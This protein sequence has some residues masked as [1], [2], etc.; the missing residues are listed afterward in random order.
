MESER[1]VEAT[2]ES[3]AASRRPR[4]NVP[5]ELTQRDR[6]LDTYLNSERAPARPPAP[7]DRALCPA[8]RT[9][10]AVKRLGRIEEFLREARGTLVR[11]NVRD[12]EPHAV[13]HDIERVGGFIAAAVVNNDLVMLALRARDA[14]AL[15]QD[16]V[17]HG[18][19]RF[20]PRAGTDIDLETRNL[21]DC[22]RCLFRARWRE[23]AVRKRRRP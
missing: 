23:A 22:P 6:E 11:I 20:I 3:A 5:T 18:T 8:G 16:Q 10:Q 21:K 17:S 2:P 1:D 7:L 12:D 14:A 4:R 13:E 19:E 15:I 9:D